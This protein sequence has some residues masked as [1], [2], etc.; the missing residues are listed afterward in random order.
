MLKSLDATP[1]PD[2]PG[3]DM[4]SHRL[5]LGCLLLALLAAVQ[6]HA[7]SAVSILLP[8]DY[9][10][11][12]DVQIDGRNIAGPKVVD[13]LSEVLLKRGRE[14]P[15]FVLIPKTARFM[16]WNNIQGIVEKVGFTNVRYFAYSH[17]DQKM[18][19]VKR[20]GPPVPFPAI[21]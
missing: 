11:K 4:T 10:K 12:W 7:E 14:I 17:D 19:E 13:E 3:I 16:D 18:V 2:P 20:E 15:V 8:L 9:G 21:P 1:R 6:S 5:R